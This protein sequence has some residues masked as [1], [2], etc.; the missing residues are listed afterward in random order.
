ML[1]LLCL[2]NGFQ[3]F[4]PGNFSVK[5]FL[6]AYIT[7]PLF[8][9]LYLGHK[10]WSRTPWIRPIETVDLWSGKEEVDRQEEEDRLLWGDEDP[11]AARGLR[12]RIWSW[13]A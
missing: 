7:L 12:Q 2:T 5:S 10:W 9:A 13:I 4:F 8:F 11:T 3:V 1:V 6:A